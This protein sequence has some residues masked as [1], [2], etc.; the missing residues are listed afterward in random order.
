[1]QV[2][3]DI[4]SAGE[5]VMEQA[6]QHFLDYLM[7]QGKLLLYFVLFVSA[8][9]ENLFPPVPGDTV[10][11]F[12]AFLVGKGKL[13]FFVVYLSTSFGSVVGFYL[14][15]YIARRFGTGFFANKRLKWTNPE[16]MDKAKNRIGRYGYFVILFNRFF[17]GIRSV[18]SI[19]A[20]LLQMNWLLVFV[21]ALLSA[22]A[23]NL[24]WIQVGYSLGNNWDTVKT[25]MENLIGKY[26]TLMGIL[27]FLLILI[28]SAVKLYRRYKAR[29]L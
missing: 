27:L 18:I 7:T 25:T 12:G 5:T 6:L 1:M 26:N 20:G 19:S 21:L 29:K 13:S 22:M 2:I 15:F 28:F 17:P 9:L 16:K 10:T 24:I 4:F 11:A 23:W 3:Q 8:I 14:L